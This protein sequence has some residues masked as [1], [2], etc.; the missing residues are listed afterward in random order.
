MEITIIDMSTNV[1]DA[2]IQL[3]RAVARAA[4]L[5]FT[6]DISGRQAAVLREI[7]ACEPVTQVGLARATASDPSALVRI[8]DDLESREFVE[9]HRSESDRREMLV[10]RP[11]GARYWD[12]WTSRTSGWRMPRQQH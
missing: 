4:A 10:S 2:I 5:T 1:L 11:R 8:L 3:R 9:R 7:G 6:G 12:R